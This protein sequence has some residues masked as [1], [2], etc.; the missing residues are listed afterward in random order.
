M[1]YLPSLAVGGALLLAVVA[2]A[3]ASV[4]NY[5]NIISGGV[6]ISGT[7]GNMIDST[8]PSTG[9]HNHSSG[10]TNS[11]VTGN[12]TSS[13]ASSVSG[14]NTTT[15]DT[16]RHHSSSS[17]SVT[18]NADIV[19]V[20]GAVSLTGG[21]Q[22]SSNSGASNGISTGNS[23]SSASSSVSNVNVTGFGN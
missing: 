8:T 22:I 11:I 5:A 20:G 15:L 9:R 2:P 14:V 17:T 13:G 7:G 12:A 18:N 16:G 23:S 3:F 6:A 19:S 10:G 1:K 4:N 21:N